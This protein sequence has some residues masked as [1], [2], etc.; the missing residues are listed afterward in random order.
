MEYQN[1]NVEDQDTNLDDDQILESGPQNVTDSIQE[2]ADHIDQGLQYIYDYLQRALESGE[3]NYNDINAKYDSVVK[4]YEQIRSYAITLQSQNADPSE[5]QDAVNQM[6]VIQGYVNEIIS[7]IDSG[8]QET[9][10]VSGG[11][12]EVITMEEVGPVR[13]WW[14][15][16]SDG[17][18]LLLKAAGIGLLVFVGK[19]AFD[20]AM[21]KIKLQ[22][23]KEV[24]EELEQEFEDNDLDSE[25]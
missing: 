9:K 12:N 24:R 16:L 20:S 10:M 25:E 5:I 8:G 11:S 13:S 7:E 2:L 17:T 3:Q 18:R 6:I 4:Q 19:R 14:N 22:N 15:N 21:E 23:V 1:V